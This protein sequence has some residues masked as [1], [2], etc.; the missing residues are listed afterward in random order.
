MIYRSSHRAFLVLPSSVNASILERIKAT[1]E[2]KYSNE[3][4]RKIR[5]PDLK[6]F[7]E[8]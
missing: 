8:V 5:K 3:P 2:N 6:I 1:A 4:S 7:G